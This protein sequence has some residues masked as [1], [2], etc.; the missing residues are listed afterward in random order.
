MKKVLQ[1]VANLFEG[2]A[3]LSVLAVGEKQMK[4]DMITG[5]KTEYLN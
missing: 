3:E 2:L 5:K 1:V 4:A